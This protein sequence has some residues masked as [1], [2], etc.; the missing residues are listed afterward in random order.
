[1]K[2]NRF[3]FVTAMALVLGGV[4]ACGQAALAQDNKETAPAKK[5][6]P[7]PEQQLERLSTE[8]TLT[9][10]QKPKVKELLESSA[11]QR[12]EFRSLGQEERRE[13]MRS[14]TADQNKKMK[15]ILTPDQYE[16]YQKL[17]ERRRQRGGAGGG[18]GAPKGDKQK[19]A[20]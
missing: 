9:D 8:L 4:L 2:I 11:K 12:Q 15:E 1:M 5:R 16:K 17:M 19:S 7:S 6:A 3:G 14:L 13:K 10:A 20:Q 18:G